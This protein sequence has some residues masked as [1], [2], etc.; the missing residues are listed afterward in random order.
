LVDVLARQ[1]TDA[2]LAALGIV[3]ELTE[4]QPI[5]REAVK[6]RGLDLAAVTPE[7]RVAEVVG[8]HDQ[9]VRPGPIRGAGGAGVEKHARE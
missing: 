4:P 7:V 2:R 6:V 3:V 8:H 1:Q 9:E 5:R